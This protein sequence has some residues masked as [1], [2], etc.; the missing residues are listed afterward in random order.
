MHLKLAVFVVLAALALAMPA[1]AQTGAAAPRWDSVGA[2][3][4]TQMAQGY[5]ADA[6]ASYQRAI[7]LGQKDAGPA[8][9]GRLYTAIGNA[10]LKLRKNDAAV[11]AYTKAAAIDPNPAIA[12]FNLCAVLYNM[13]QATAQTI[14]TCDKAIAADPKK[15]DAYFIKGSVMLGNASIGKDNKTIVPPGTVETL[16]QYLV[17]APNGPHAMDVKQMLDFVK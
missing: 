13:G 11:A 10:N 5:Y 1:S 17:L 4:N 6:I 16:K 12:Y 9:I 15:A 7:D 2:L 14:A 8:A 3:G